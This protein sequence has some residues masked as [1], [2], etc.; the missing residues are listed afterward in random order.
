MMTLI[1][2]K[3]PLAS[4]GR[5]PRAPTTIGHQLVPFRFFVP[6]EG[7]C[8]GIPEVLSRSFATIPILHPFSLFFERY[9]PGSLCISAAIPSSDFLIPVFHDFPTLSPEMKGENI[10]FALVAYAT[11]R[12]FGIIIPLSRPSDSRTYHCCRNLF[13]RQPSHGQRAKKL[14]LLQILISPH[15]HLM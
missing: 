15:P 1:Y 4:I 3:G 13:Q 2:G 5:G 14:G 9:L 10:L 12:A 8:L 7:A 6:L 11:C